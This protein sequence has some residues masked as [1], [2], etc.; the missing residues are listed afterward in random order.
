MREKTISA[1]RLGAFSDGV[2]AV[3]ITVMVLELKAPDGSHLADLLPLWPTAISYGVSYLFIAI[4][5][6]N[7]HHLM[8]FVHQVTPRLIWLNF[9]HLFVV[10]LLP[11]TTAWVARSHM[12]PVP[13]AL[14]AAIFLLVDLAYLVFEREVLAQA[15]Q[16][17]M[18]DRIR[19][20]VQR[21]TRLAVAVFA[22]GAIVAPFMPLSGFGIVCAALL[23][24]LS[25]EAINGQSEQPV[26]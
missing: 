11:F 12:A 13:V 25:P 17:A 21:R 2:I 19:K 3:I 8:H 4:I 14:Y 24:Y 26:H 18:P 16:A 7:H 23:L 15:D 1:D 22:T 10:S 9:A 5:W 6:V 20:R